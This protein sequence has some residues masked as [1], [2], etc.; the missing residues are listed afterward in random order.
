[1]NAVPRNVRN[2]NPGNVEASELDWQGLADPPT[3]GVYLVFTDPKWG[4]RCMA[5]CLMTDYRRGMVTVDQL[6]TSWA[7][8]SE[9]N[10]HAYVTDVAGRLGQGLDETLSLPAELLPLLKA[11]ATHEGGCP[12]PDQVIQAGIDSER[13]G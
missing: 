12:W 2:N 6:I 10:T 3:D 13:S 8:P 7:P 5:R 11:I 4:F 1:V 9:N